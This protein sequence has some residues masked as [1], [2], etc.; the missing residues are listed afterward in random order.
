VRTGSYSLAP[1]IPASP[2]RRRRRA[3]TNRLL[4]T[5]PEL[6]THS[7]IPPSHPP[8]VSRIP[9]AVAFLV[10]ARSSSSES[11][12]ALSPPSLPY[13]CE[14]G[15]TSKYQCNQFMQGEIRIYQKW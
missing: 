1:L 10:K 7:R 11:P 3:H 4:G 15:W 9:G 14:T 12:G 2:C 5:G 13:W 8:S 6:G